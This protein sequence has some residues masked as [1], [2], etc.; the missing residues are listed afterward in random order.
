MALQISLVV[1]SD[2]GS[3]IKTLSFLNNT[4]GFTLVHNGYAPGM[5]LEG[6]VSDVL[7][8]KATGTSNDDLAGHLQA[9]EEYFQRARWSNESPER[10]D[11]W[12]RVQQTSESGARKALVVGGAHGDKVNFYSHPGMTRNK[13]VNYPVVIDRL[14]IWEDD[15]A[16]NLDIQDISSVGGK[17]GLTI[18]PGDVPCRIAQTRLT[19]V[20]AAALTEYWWGFR[21]ARFGTVANFVSPWEC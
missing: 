12:L 6:V 20:S 17:G 1:K 11:V 8:V 19:G 3:D 16:F 5:A 10:Y 7:T 2:L 18:T 14:P 15:V 4:A 9:L 21:S 13:L